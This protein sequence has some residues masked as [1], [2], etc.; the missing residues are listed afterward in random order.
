M[1]NKEVEPDKFTTTTTPEGLTITVEHD[2]LFDGPLR[3]QY[4]TRDKSFL[5]K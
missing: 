3:K 1:K 2:S 5:K 4:T